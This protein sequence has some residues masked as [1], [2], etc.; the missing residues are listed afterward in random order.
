ML[1]LIA[2]VAILLAGAAATTVAAQDATVQSS[3]VTIS[4]VGDTGESAVTIDADNGVGIANVEVTVDT[5][6]AEIT[7]VQ[8]GSDVNTSAPAVNF[9]VSNVTQDSV[10][11]EYANIGADSEDIGGFELALVNLTSVGAGNATVTLSEDG[12]YGGG[13]SQYANVALTEGG[14]SVSNTTSQGMDGGQDGSEDTQSTPGFTM[15]A[16]LVAI[17]LVVAGRR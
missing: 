11:I 15:V 2:T 10:T 3:D 7:D 16:A 14:L 5:S 8:P 4:D 9:A 6:V 17:S 1:A 13:N 12:V